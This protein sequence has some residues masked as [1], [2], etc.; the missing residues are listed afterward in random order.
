MSDE[1]TE[2]QS[3][4]VSYKVASLQKKKYHEDRV[5]SHRKVQNLSAIQKVFQNKSLSV[6]EL[7]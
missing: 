5:L 6:I 1:R 3:D 4:K 7:C 2:R